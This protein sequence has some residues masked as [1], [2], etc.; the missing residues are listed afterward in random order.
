MC[1][2]Y[3][4]FYNG[5]SNGKERENELE[6]G[7]GVPFKGVIGGYIGLSR[8]IESLGLWGVRV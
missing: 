5:K 2:G 7:I 8:V 4:G 6:T 3:V 1:R